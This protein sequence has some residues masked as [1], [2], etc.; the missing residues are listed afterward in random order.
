M[1]I[2]AAI[3]KTAEAITQTAQA[4]HVEKILFIDGKQVSGEYACSQMRL[5]YVR[6]I[7]S[8]PLAILVFLIIFIFV[9]REAVNE[10][11]GRLIKAGPG[12]AEFASKPNNYEET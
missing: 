6:A 8:I 4:I 1:A 2:S 7:F 10:L 11:L 5:E 3:I 9:F 12:G